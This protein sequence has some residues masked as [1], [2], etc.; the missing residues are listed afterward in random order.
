[1]TWAVRGDLSRFRFR[2]TW[3]GFSH[4]YDPQ[5]LKSESSKP[6]RKAMLK[7][8]MLALEMD[9]H[10]ILPL[11]DIIFRTGY[12]TIELDLFPKH[13]SFLGFCIFW[14]YLCMKAWLQ[15]ISCN[16]FWLVRLYVIPVI[17]GLWSCGL[18]W[19][20]SLF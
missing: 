20:L 13:D 3:R 6:H 19:L 12:S 9:L 10:Q 5:L 15:I 2:G 8:Y 14:S 7:V 17:I 16:V 18:A 4:P 11:T 1:M